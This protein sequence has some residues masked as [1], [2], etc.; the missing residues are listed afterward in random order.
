MRRGWR[1]LVENISWLQ[2]GA[3]PIP[4]YSEFMPAPCV[5]ITPCGAIDRELFRDDDPDGWY[6]TEYEER[7]ELRPGLQ[8]IARELIGLFDKLARG[9]PGHGIAK[10]KLDG[11]PC[12]PDALREAGAPESE[13]GVLIL[14]LA[15]SRTQ[16]DKGRVRWTLFGGSDDGASA[17]FWRSFRS[18]DEFRECAA[19][20]LHGVYGES[21]LDRFRVY[22]D[23]ALASTLA[24]REGNSL[25][26]VDSL[27]TFTP[28]AQLPET[29]QRAYLAGDLRLLPFPG[30]LLVFH[31]VPYRK[32]QTQL[33]TAMQI[34]LLH[35]I[36][37]SEAVH[38]IRVPQ[39]GWMHEPRNGRPVINAH[40]HG[41]MRN[42]MHRT[43]R[44][45]RVY[46]HENEL[47]VL[48]SEDK[49]AHILFSAAEQDLGLYGKPMARNV[50]MWS[51]DYEM[52]LD[53]PNASRDQLQAAAN[54][55][56]DGGLFGY[57]F[58]YPPMRVGEHEVYWH[59]PLIAWRS[60]EGEAEVLPDAPLGYLRSAGVCLAPRLLTR[61][62]HLAVIETLH[63]NPQ[64]RGSARKVLQAAEAIGGPL[65]RSFARALLTADKHETLDEWLAR[66]PEQIRTAV[67]RVLSRSGRPRPLKST[68]SETSSR[69]FETRYWRTIAKLAQGRFINKDNA[70][71][72]LDRASQSQLVHHWRDLEKLGDFLLGYYAALKKRHHAPRAVVGAMPFH[73]DTDFAFR[74]SGGWLDDHDR[75]TEQ[76]NIVFMIPGRDRSRAVIMGDHYDTAYMEDRYGT[77]GRGP[78]LAA[79]GAD[80]NH[81][82]TAALMLA[83]PIFLELSRARKLACDIWLVHLTGEEFPSDCLGARHVCRSAVEQSLLIRTD[84]GKVFDAGKVRIKGA[85]ILDM[86]AHNNDHAR[87]IFQICPGSGRESMLL[88][89]SAHE[90]A[91]AW[92]DFVEEANQRGT[93]ANAQPAQRSV[94]PR[95]IPALAPH[96]PLHADVRPQSDPHSTLYNT[97]AQIFSDA[98]IPVVLFMENYDINRHGYHDSHDTMENIDLD[99]GAAL[100]AIAIETVA[101]VASA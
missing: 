56:A 8:H 80:D 81:S 82:A 29:V 62:E 59:R 85:F 100:T 32:M 2:D 47:E 57:R 86:V 65:D 96:L 9:E 90:A 33:A 92:N 101:R 4:A 72:V 89:R 12:W 22:D 70:D 42:T 7:L 94:D 26:G 11:N 88:A 19:R 66:M 39:S 28:F 71:C 40:H 99:Y 52:L 74:W 48:R 60:A 37:R 79:P 54:A 24:W 44:W 73:W 61:P 30:S 77:S 64:A 83:A 46:R 53:G 97:D 67:G 41:P 51:H 50:Q 10:K 6:V 21:S 84:R 13:R 58:L 98:G 14:P 93:R 17:P 35:M 45:E 49:V 18:A 75:K 34:P 20:L 91:T 76:R 31:A 25:R 78:R 68:F 27:L 87:D 36:E 63:H 95:R 69:A 15:L 55:L 1:A 5:G 16:D 3:Y 43:H 23:N 38:S